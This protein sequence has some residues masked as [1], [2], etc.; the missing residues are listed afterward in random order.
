MGSYYRQQV[1][2]YQKVADCRVTAERKRI[3]GRGGELLERRAEVNGTRP[4]TTDTPTA[5]CR[6]QRGPWTERPEPGLRWFPPEARGLR[7][8]ERGERQGTGPWGFTALSLL[9][10]PNFSTGNA[11][12]KNEWA[13]DIL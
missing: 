4:L 13:I 6:C 3:E 2:I 1:I 7:P 10:P 8:E 11:Q 12:E 5:V 9:S